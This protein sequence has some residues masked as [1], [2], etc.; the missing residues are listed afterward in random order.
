ML[1]R[2]AEH[3][4]WMAR[5]LERAE[6]TARLINVT[7]LLLMDLPRTEHFGWSSIN[8]ITGNREL[9]DALHPEA[10]ERNVV[11][12]AVGDRRNPGSIL[13]SLESARGNARSIRE[14]IPRSAWESLN[15]LQQ[16]AARDVRVAL[17][18]QRRFDY[19]Q[20]VILEAQKLSGILEGTMNRDQGYVFMQL[21]RTLERAD[22]TTRIVDARFTRKI[23]DGGREFENLEWMSVLRSLSAYQTYRRRMQVRVQ[24]AEVL[25]FLLQDVEMPRS[26]HYCL[27][28]LEADL[29]LLPRHHAPIE[30]A[31]RLKDVIAEAVP[32]G[33]GQSE[34]QHFND[35]L[36][37]GL[38]DLDGQIRETY[39]SVS[40]AAGQ[41]GILAGQA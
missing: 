10:S 40:E 28:K 30:T 39:F 32:E 5:Y 38:I 37:V 6:S 29:F 35:R 11:R 41:A 27:R 7:A 4:Y 13:S 25:R 8:V 9:F 14:I 20:S 2:V 3:I 26:F 23:P 12:F 18:Q 24:R 31:R 33:L 34:L 19:L 16:S 15:A 22:M 36:Q 1:S 17:S 21:G